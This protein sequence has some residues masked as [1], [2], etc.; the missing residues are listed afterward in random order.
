MNW[1]LISV[2]LNAY[3]WLFFYLFYYFCIQKTHNINTKGANKQQQQQKSSMQRN[4]KNI[5]VSI[6]HNF[7]H[8]KRQLVS[9]KEGKQ[10][11]KAWGTSAWL[12]RVI[13]L[14]SVRIIYCYLSLQWYKDTYCKCLQLSCSQT[15]TV[16]DSLWLKTDGWQHIAMLFF[17]RNH[18]SVA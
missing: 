17:L 6:L 11:A 4:E 13:P 9:G 14:I 7:L 18:T 3:C 8:N 15:A 12:L 2:D 5:V 10:F 1:F 16:A